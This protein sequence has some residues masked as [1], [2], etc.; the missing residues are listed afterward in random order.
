MNRIDEQLDL[1]PSRKESQAHWGTDEYSNVSGGDLIQ[2]LKDQAIKVDALKSAY[3]TLQ[4]QYRNVRNRYYGDYCKN[5]YRLRSKRE[6]CKTYLQTEM[7]RVKT[8]LD[9]AKTKY[10]SANAILSDI[11]DR[12]KADSDAVQT[13]AD[14]G[15]TPDSILFDA[16]AEQRKKLI[17]AGGI[18]LVIGVV[19]FMMYK[20]FKK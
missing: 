9:A 12:V 4:I 19:G 14:Q 15:K 5:K 17:I 10:D 18:V 7:G 8:K 16:K 3:G 13:L 6:A 20:K 2:E 1:S 11:K